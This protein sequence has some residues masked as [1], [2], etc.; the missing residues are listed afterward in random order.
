MIKWMKKLWWFLFVWMVDVVIRV[1]WVLNRINKDKGDESLPLQ[2][3]RRHVVNVIFLKYSKEGT[4]SLSHLRTR[5]ILSDICYDDTKHYQVQSEHRRIQNPL[6]YLRGSAYAQTVNS[7]R[8]FTGF[9]KT[10]HLR[11]LKGFWIRLCWRQ[12]LGVQKELSMPLREM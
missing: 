10:L 8:S 4:L 6:K 5:N 1:A 3:F 2:E 9:A 12:V 7:L 11:C